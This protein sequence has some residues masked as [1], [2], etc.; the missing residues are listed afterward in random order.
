ME[1]P[2]ITI[3]KVHQIIGKLYME[4]AMKEEQLIGLL[5]QQGEAINKQMDAAEDSKL[6]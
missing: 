6:D 2:Q 1:Q 4:S 3:E 5:Q